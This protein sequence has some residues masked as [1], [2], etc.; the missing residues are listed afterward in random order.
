V[1]F[2]QLVPAFCSLMTW[3]PLTALLVQQPWMTP[4]LTGLPVTAAPAA[5]APATNASAA[6]PVMTN[7][8]GLT[9]SS[10]LADVSAIE[11]AAGESR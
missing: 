3:L 5:V 9:R 6:A 7:L 10:P 8:F 2:G 11:A 1:P 4:E